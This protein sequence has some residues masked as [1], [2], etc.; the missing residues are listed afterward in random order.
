MKPKGHN[1]FLDEADL[2]HV[3]EAFVA[4]AGSEYMRATSLPF[5]LAL[6]RITGHTLA[7]LLPS[8]DRVDAV[9]GFVTPNGGRTLIDAGGCRADWQCSGGKKVLLSGEDEL[10]ADFLGRIKPATLR[11][12]VQRI[13]PLAECVAQLAQAQR[14]LQEPS[15][16]ERDAGVSM[17]RM[18]PELRAFIFTHA[19]AHLV[20]LARIAIERNDAPLVRNLVDLG[21]DV[22][23][24]SFSGDT[25]LSYA[26]QHARQETVRDLLARGADPNLWIAP[27]DGELHEERVPLHR[28]IDQPDIMQLLL[29]AGAA[30]D[31][32]TAKNRTALH[33][34][35]R[36]DHVSSAAL[37]LE[38]GADLGALD[39]DG[40][41]PLEVAQRRNST[42]TA[43]VLRSAEALRHC[44]SALEDLL[45]PPAP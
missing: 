2:K 23:A 22:N 11:A 13:R 12:Q 38:A 18:A 45:S 4:G 43:E 40:R 26:A 29:Q 36:H 20:T 35:A 32:R 39:A 27:A 7:V 16:T 41:T 37:L 9:H 30:A 6:H 25:L 33:L 28:A 15:G 34:A 10:I 31:M 19:K 21:F 5:A 1:L 17:A 14:Q 3:L 44:R 8:T 24:T 42:R